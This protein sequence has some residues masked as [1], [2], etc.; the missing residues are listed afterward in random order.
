[1][2]SFARKAKAKM[3][4]ATD[5]HKLVQPYSFHIIFGRQPAL[6]HIGRKKE[7]AFDGWR[8]QATR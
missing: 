5:Q 6:F 3:I 2:E 7:T 1:M 8:I 4:A